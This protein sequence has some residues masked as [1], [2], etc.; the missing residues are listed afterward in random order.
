MININSKEWAELTGSDI[1]EFLSSP[2][3]E[4]SFF[5]E[6]KDDRVNSKKVAEEISALANTYGGYIFLGVSDDKKIEGC[7][8][9]NEQRIQT[10][11][12]D[13]ITPTPS[14]DIKKFVCENQIV[15]VIRIDEGAEPPY[16]TSQGKIYER[17]ASGSCVVKDSAR[18][19]QMYNKQET[20]LQRLM[21]VL[22]IPPINADV[23]NIYGYIDIGFSLTLS[24]PDYVIR[25]FVDT[26]LEL[27]ARD[28]RDK[29]S[30]SSLYRIAKSIVFM[31]GGLSA[32]E[33]KLPAHL[34]NFI[35]I[36]R[37]GSVRMRLLLMNNNA[38]EEAANM[39]Y[40]LFYL[41]SFRNIYAKIMGNLFPNYFIFAKKY[42]ELTTL[43]Q[44]Q[45]VLRYEPNML[46]Q[47][48]ANEENNKELLDFY[49]KKQEIY[50]VNRIITNDRVPKT[51]LLTIDKSA[52]QKWGVKE[53]TADSIID[54]LFYSWFVPMNT[55]SALQ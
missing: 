12:H 26:D 11:I 14:F 17:L 16:I 25:T 2:E 31:P 49:S 43:K 10:T 3:T 35:E 7:N 34:N 41:R 21:D 6:F 27:I 44:F 15:F 42:E 1:V 32:G 40:P 28:I 5:F 30:Q 4:E 55:P 47:D 51:G 38:E 48:P 22:S 23:G 53:Y 33:N 9:W 29:T 13:S 36:M 54:E 37:D 20:R 24:D 8:A 39:I 46:A 18:L 19:T 45:P 50:G 52:M